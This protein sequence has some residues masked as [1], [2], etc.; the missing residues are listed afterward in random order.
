M[1]TSGLGGQPGMNM[2]TGMTFSISQPLQDEALMWKTHG[3]RFLDH[4]ASFPSSVRLC[5]TKACS[6]GF[7]NKLYRDWWASYLFASG[8][9]LKPYVSGPQRPR[10]W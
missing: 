4:V 10:A 3:E 5:S 9:D 1:M 2:S 7:P 8:L 6:A